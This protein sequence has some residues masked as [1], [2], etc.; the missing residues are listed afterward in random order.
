MPQR[1]TAEYLPCDQPANLL[2]RLVGRTGSRAEVQ[3]VDE[4]SVPSAVA[5]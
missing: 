2:Q 5:P 4:P 3:S 1:G